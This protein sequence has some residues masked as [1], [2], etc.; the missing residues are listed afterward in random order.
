MSR[1]SDIERAEAL[2]QQRA[3]IERKLAVIEAAQRKR[4]RAE[5]TRRKVLAGAMLLHKAESN[6]DFQTDLL[7]Q[8]DGFLVRPDDRALFGL[9]PKPET[10]NP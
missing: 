7:R 8:L 2:R 4:A 9:P 6:P 10:G 5:D 3:K 1:K